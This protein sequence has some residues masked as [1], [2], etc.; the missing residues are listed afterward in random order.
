MPAP[1]SYDDPHYSYDAPG[2]K[3]DNGYPFLSLK[4]RIRQNYTQTL[5]ARAWI[6]GPYR[7][8]AKAAIQRRQ[9]WPIPETDDP[10]WLVFTHTQLNIRARISSSFGHPTRLLSM[11]AKISLGGTR[12]SQFRAKIVP[13]QYLSIR[14]SIRPQFYTTRIPLY[15]SIRGEAQT[16]AR[17]VFYIS[18]NVRQESL[19]LKA[20]IVK[21]S[22]YRVTGR[23]LVTG[24][25]SRSPVIQ[26]S[27]PV[28]TLGNRQSLSIRARIT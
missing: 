13:G 10:G 14:A 26:I 25:G 11:Q 17:M 6:T 12:T 22:T 9:G 24:K 27:G 21:E 1:N 19:G 28:A 7:F 23:F 18:G 5:Q 4:A 3:Y 16:S 20:C 15:F 2:I 8:T